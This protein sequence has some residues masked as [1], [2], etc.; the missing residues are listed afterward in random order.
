[1]KYSVSRYYDIS[2]YPETDDDENFIDRGDYLNYS[3][4]VDHSTK[5]SVAFSIDTNMEEDLSFYMG[6]ILSSLWF[7]DPAHSKGFRLKEVTSK[8]IMEELEEIDEYDEHYCLIL[9]KSIELIWKDQLNSDIVIPN[10]DCY[11]DQHPI[12]ELPF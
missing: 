6:K 9:A 7:L 8:G 12:D 3:L 4:Q 5:D 2:I 10:A 11:P 1:M